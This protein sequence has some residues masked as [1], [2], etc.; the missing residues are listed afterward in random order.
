MVAPS[1]LYNDNAACIQWAHNM[2]SKKIRHMELCKNAVCEWVHDGAI[3]VCHIK[4]RV[5]P[6]DIFTKEMMDGAH[7]W[8][9]RDSFMCRLSNFLHHSLLVI[10]HNQSFP[11]LDPHPLASSAA[12]TTALWTHNSYGAVLCFFSLMSNPFKHFSSIKCGSSS[13]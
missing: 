9:L 13:Y 8:R 7:F 11:M 5:N 10:Y 2:T 3:T 4:G 12:T 6:A 1:L